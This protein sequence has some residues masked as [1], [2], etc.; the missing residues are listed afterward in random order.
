[1]FGKFIRYIARSFFIRDFLLTQYITSGALTSDSER[2]QLVRNPSIPR[3]IRFNHLRHLDAITAVEAMAA[4]PDSEEYLGSRLF[5][6][7][8][9]STPLGDRALAVSASRTDEFFR[10]TQDFTEGIWPIGFYSLLAHDLICWIDYENRYGNTIKDILLGWPSNQQTLTTYLTNFWWWCITLAATPIVLGGW[11]LFDK[12]R[13]NDREALQILNAHHPSF[14]SDTIW[15]LLNPFSKTKVSLQKIQRALLW[16]KDVYGDD[17]PHLTAIIEFS[18]QSIGLARLSVLST[19]AKVA[20]IDIQSHRDLSTRE[21]WARLQAVSDIALTELKRNAGSSINFIR[22]IYA[23]YLLWSLGHSERRFLELVIFW[24]YMAALVYAKLRLGEAFVQFIYQDIRWLVNFYK[25]RQQDK[26]WTYMAQVAEYQCTVCGNWTDIA[27]ANVFSAQSCLDDFFAVPRTPEEISNMLYRVHHLG[28]NSLNLSR[29]DWNKWTTQELGY[30]LNLTRAASHIQH[31]KIMDLSCGFAN[32]HILDPERAYL[33]ARFFRATDLEYL[34]FSNR[35]IGSNATTIIIPQLVGN[36]L[37]YV[38]LSGNTISSPGMHA[39][40]AAIADL[41]NLQVLKI[42]GNG[43]TNTEIFQFAAVSNYTAIR[44]LGL[45]NNRFGQK[46]LDILAGNFSSQLKV[47]DLSANDF[48]GFNLRNLGRNSQHLQELCLATTNIGD[49]EFSTLTSSLAGSG[50]RVLDVSNNHLTEAGAKVFAQAV[51]SSRLEIVVFSDNK[52][53]AEGI[54]YISPALVNSSVKVFIMR[55]NDVGDIGIEFFSRFLPHT[56]LRILNLA[57]NQL[58]QLAAADLAVALPH[59]Q[60]EEVD[61]SANDLGDA[62]ITEF[63]RVMKNPKSQ[64]QIVRLANN[65]ITPK[66][67]ASLAYALSNHSAVTLVTQGCSHLFKF[68]IALCYN[69]YI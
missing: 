17:N 37:S 16:R 40:A 27:Y 46:G 43:L 8:G 61:L 13:V 3:P 66:G 62:G 57:D 28:F 26:L 56:Q 18:R 51:N 2:E 55:G 9:R 64:L 49:D 63:S 29:Q 41:P 4:L 54:A 33:L 19:L 32:P 44:M 52:I 59:S 65:K 14:L 24:P 11:R 58:T 47:L 7:L 15:W 38:D 50:L 68:L 21:F 1:M 35:G 22:Y 12:R 23:N 20:D 45:G 30:I 25:C 42:S 10:G 67:A 34:D 6:L 53:S 5:G 36:N 31:L 60:V 69:L 39:L 48:S